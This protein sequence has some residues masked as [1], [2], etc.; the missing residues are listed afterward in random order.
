ME[1]TTMPIYEYRCTSCGHELE[2]LQKFSDAP[3]TT[4]DK[5]G[6]PVR[7]L[8]STSAFHLKGGGWYK[9]DYSS[10]S[11]SDAGK[12]SDSAGGCP[13]GSCGSSTGAASS[14]SSS[15]GWPTASASSRSPDLGSPSIRLVLL[16]LPAAA[17]AVVCLFLPIPLAPLLAVLLSLD[18]LFRSDFEDGSLEQWVLSPH[19]LPLLVLAKVLAHWLFSGLA[20]VI[21][22]PLLALMLGLPVAC[23]YPAFP[24]IDLDVA[25]EYLLMA[26]TLA[27]IKSRMLLP[28]TGEAVEEEGDDLGA[29]RDRR[30]E[31]EFARAVQVVA[32]R[33][34][35]V[36]T[37]S[38][39]GDAQPLDFLGLVRTN[40]RA[41]RGDDGTHALAD[42]PGQFSSHRVS[43]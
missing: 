7:K 12:T 14:P 32:D 25:G 9:T 19:P 3:L 22:S 11:A 4:C 27:W 42:D 6:G 13:S 34:D 31:E 20:L 41:I 16:V 36:E 8:M 10:S 18:G 30:H 40:Q 24:Q 35:A 28:P 29:G 2:A 23:Q 37:D 1:A 38:H 17:L 26:A 39:V 15:S 21:L 5:C 43:A 33:A